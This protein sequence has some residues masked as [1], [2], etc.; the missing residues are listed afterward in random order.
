M[1]PAALAL[2]LQFAH[3][4]PGISVRTMAGIVQVE[5]GGDPLA[6]GDNT[7]DRSY[8]LSDRAAAEAFARRLLREGHSLDLGLAQIN[9]ANLL[10]VGLTLTGVFDP[11][12][13][14]RAAA[15]IFR[16]DYVLARRRFGASQLALRRALGMYNTGRLD[17]GG[18]Y[19]ERG[20]RQPAR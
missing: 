8:H 14:L 17:A 6:I 9:D 12:R 7:S 15:Q 5:S 18:G 10:R 13:N 4:A 11:C 1:I 19:A 2:T 20:R 16:E 3:C